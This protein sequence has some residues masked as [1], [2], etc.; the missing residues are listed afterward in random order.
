MRVRACAC[1][2]AYLHVVVFDVSSAEHGHDGLAELLTQG[3]VQQEVCGAVQVHQEVSY[4]GQHT[5][6]VGGLYFDVVH[7]VR[8]VVHQSRHLA[9]GGAGVRWRVLCGGRCMACVIWLLYCG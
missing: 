4:V 2:C 8:Q 9:R 3:A 7:G 6:T 5:V 1:A